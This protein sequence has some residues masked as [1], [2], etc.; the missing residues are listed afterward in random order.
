MPSNNPFGFRPAR[1]LSGGTIR[2]DEYTIA[3]TYN[4]AIYSGD[5]VK[6]VAGGG[7]ELAA[8]GDRVLGIFKG[9]QYTGS[10]GEFHFSAYWPA[11]QALLTGTTAKAMVFTDPNIVYEVQSGGTPTIADN[12][13][14]A[15]HVAGTGSAVSGQSGAYLSGTMTSADA[16]FRVHRLVDKP[17]NS[18]Q[19]ALLEVSIFEH[20]F[21]RNDAA[22][23]GV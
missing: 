21:S 8:A 15:D 14:L 18:G 22:T 4:T 7:I 13:T 10:D 23:P 17:G 3:S 9:V 1:H 20:E 12:F 16:G 2:A 11:S 6:A 5:P 19:Y